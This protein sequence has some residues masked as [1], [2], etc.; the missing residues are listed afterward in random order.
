MDTGTWLDDLEVRVAQRIDDAHP[1]LPRSL[2]VLFDPGCAL[3]QR[4]RSW[5]LGQASYVPLTFVACDGAEARRRYGD[6]PW[7]GDELVVVSDRGGVWAG[8][9]AFLTCLWALV[10]WR[11]WSFRLAAPAFAPLVERFFHALSSRRRSL[12]R[13]FDHECRDGR[14]AVRPR[15]R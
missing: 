4:C 13:F 12:A 1:Q 14:C 2:T 3:C 10:D 5:M 11:E 7:L 9:A 6:I 15:E 8:P